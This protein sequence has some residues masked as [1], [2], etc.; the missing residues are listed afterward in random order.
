MKITVIGSTGG[1]GRLV[2]D[3][4]VRRGHEVTAFA[5]QAPALA[6]VAGAAGT[7]LP[8]SSVRRI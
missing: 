4:A 7:I 6:G 5:R 3:E 1:N 2:L 8:S